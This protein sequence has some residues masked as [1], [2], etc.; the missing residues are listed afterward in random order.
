MKTKL[1]ILLSL[2]YFNIT[3]QTYD[4]YRVIAYSNDSIEVISV[5]NTIRVL[6]KQTLYVP[7]VFSPD[8]D[9]IN[10]LFFVKGNG[11]DHITIEIYNRWGQMVFE[12]PHLNERWDGT[13]RGKE[14]PMGTY[15]YQ[16]LLDKKRVT[17]GTVTLVR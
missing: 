13:F 15:V 4:I 8:G 12:A 7:N 3:G 16:L 14:C 1:I 9:G 6:V 10:D 2:L 11:L 5:S 17:S